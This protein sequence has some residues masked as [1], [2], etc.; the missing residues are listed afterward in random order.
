M[1]FND[2]LKLQ[3]ISKKQAAKDLRL[4]YVHLVRISNGQNFVSLEI[5][6]AIY[7][8]TY[9]RVGFDNWIDLWKDKG[10]LREYTKHLPLNT[11]DLKEKQPNTNH[12]SQSKSCCY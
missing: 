7:Q 9:G 8:Y 1:N 12:P 3:R 10:K 4:A 11:F 2:Y 6:I 5:A